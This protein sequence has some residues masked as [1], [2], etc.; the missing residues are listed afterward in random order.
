MSLGFKN[1][2]LVNFFLV[3]ITINYINNETLFLNNSFDIFIDMDE[4][5]KN[6]F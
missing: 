6:I 5:K 1:Y 3:P 2:Y 4:E